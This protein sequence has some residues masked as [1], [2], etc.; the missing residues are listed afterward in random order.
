MSAGAFWILVA[1]A[2]AYAA[3]EAKSHVLMTAAVILA[4]Y[5]VREF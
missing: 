1:L 2:A 4:I 3:V 5:G